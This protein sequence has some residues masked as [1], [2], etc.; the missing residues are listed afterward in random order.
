MILYGKQRQNS[1]NS[2]NRQNRQ[3]SHPTTKLQIKFAFALGLH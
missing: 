2:Q 3:N 1:Q